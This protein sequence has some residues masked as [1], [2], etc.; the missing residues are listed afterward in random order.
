[1]SRIFGWSVLVAVLS[2]LITATSFNYRGETATAYRS[3]ID[4]ST[5]AATNAVPDFDV[6]S[7]HL[8]VHGP[9]E[10]RSQ[11]TIRPAQGERVWR[12]ADDDRD[13]FQA[14]PG[15]PC[16]RPAQ[17]IGTSVSGSVPDSPPPRN[18][19]WNRSI[20]AGDPQVAAGPD[21]LVI[22][23]YDQIVFVN[24]KSGEPLPVKGTTPPKLT[25]PIATGE[26]FAPMMDDIN[27]NLNLTD[28]EKKACHDEGFDCNINRFYDTR[29]IYDEYRSRF[30][31]VSLAISKDIHEKH[32]GSMTVRAARRG[33]LAVAVST[34]P[35]PRDG[36]HLYWWDSIPNDGQWP[37]TES[38]REHASDYPSVGISPKLFL[39]EHHAGFF[40]DATRTVSI[41]EADP[42]A[43]G[44]KPTSSL[45]SFQFWNFKDPNGNSVISCIQPAVHHGPI[46]PVFAA[47]FAST[48]RDGN[49]SFMMLYY[50]NDTLG[51][52]FRAQ[53]PIAA[54][55]GPRD[56]PQPPDPKAP[57][58]LSFQMTNTGNE[59]IK[60]AFANGLVFATFNDCR[61]LT[62]SQ[63]C[64]TSV[65]LV[66]I[67]IGDPNIVELDQLIGDRFR[68]EPT[69]V[70]HVFF[71][72]PGV[73]VNH[74]GDAALIYMRSGLKVFPEAAYSVLM[75]DASNIST[76]R[77]LQ[78]GSSTRIAQSLKCETVK[79]TCTPAGS[80]AC[81]E[82]IDRECKS[83]RDLDTAG[84][85]VDPTDDS[86]WIAD[87]FTDDKG[88]FRLAVGQILG[89]TAAKP[90][91][92]DQ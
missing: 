44:E 30:W 11:S 87:A 2:A 37:P 56:A 45:K 34:S 69:S 24:K 4:L 51:R 19:P 71:G 80:D 22:S 89:R 12:D 66:K 50:F 48:F 91:Q 20:H 84:I 49:D 27:A 23:D 15:E 46:P 67:R 68:N 76:G 61:F 18:P 28:A 6:D 82:E 53:V 36:W 74:A 47:V 52:F 29:V 7:K 8:T 32:G 86:I 35:D 85:S 13:D 57:N 58:L 17:C 70:G 38:F 1:M 33:K 16:R 90:T 14:P 72:M 64:V 10:F 31:V 59:V 40:H 65:R 63:G 9:F 39:E 79:K 3:A 75:R 78:A 92:K 41:V 42:L 81:N 62:G 55:F 43:H 88:R 60:A 54:F 21:C 26:L 83:E 25:T 77:T 73:E 5:I